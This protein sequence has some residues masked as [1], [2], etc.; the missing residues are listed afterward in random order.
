[1][2]QRFIFRLLVCLLILNLDACGDV[3]TLPEQAGVG[4]HPTLPPPNLTL[5][6]TVNVAPAKGWPRPPALALCSPQRRCTG[7]RNQCPTLARR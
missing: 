3:A 2:H 4:P 7:C 1:M 6:P 5:L